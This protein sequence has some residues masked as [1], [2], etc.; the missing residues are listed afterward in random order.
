MRCDRLR[1]IN[2][3][4]L[5]KW[6]LSEKVYYTHFY[7]VLIADPTVYLATLK[8]TQG[9]GGELIGVNFPYPTQYHLDAIIVQ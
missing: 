1:M 6:E 3:K 9:G 2:M 8:P 4:Y 7:S 5:K